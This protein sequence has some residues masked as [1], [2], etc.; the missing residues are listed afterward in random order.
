[1]AQS[2]AKIKGRKER[3]S[4]IAIPK[5]VVESEQYSKLSSHSVKLLIDLSAQ[6]NGSNNGDLCAAW[7]MMVKRGWRSKGTLYRAVSELITTG[8]ILLTRQGGKHKASLYAVT[9]KPIDECKGKLE[10]K[11]TV[12]APATWKK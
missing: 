9:F 1:M 3:G 12:V 7:S 5:I 11:A 8:F 2:R 4:F 6:Y 10:V